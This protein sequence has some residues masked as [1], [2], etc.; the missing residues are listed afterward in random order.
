MHAR[1]QAALQSTE[2]SLGH[3]RTEAKV[4]DGERIGVEKAII[5]TN[6]DIQVGCLPAAAQ[7][8]QLDSSP[9]REAERMWGGSSLTPQLS[10]AWAED[11]VAPH[12]RGLHH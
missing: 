12:Q 10:A 6:T 9:H 4:L 1:L 5:K 2:E 7:H 8:G 11:L 3:L